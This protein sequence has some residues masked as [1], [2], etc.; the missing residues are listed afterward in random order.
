MDAV[1]GAITAP[2]SA[3]VHHYSTMHESDPCYCEP[4]KGCIPSLWE[5]TQ[6][7]YVSQ[8]EAEVDSGF[9]GT[10]PSPASLIRQA[11]FSSLFK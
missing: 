8:N 6:S 9:I 2:Y 4:P 3:A 11:A 10:R 1:Q 7:V 5:K